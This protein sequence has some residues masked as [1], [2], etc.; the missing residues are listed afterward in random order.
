MKCVIDSYAWLEYFMGTPVGLKAKE[1]LESSSIE[2][3]VPSICMCEVYT[4][5]L[6]TESLEKAELFRGFMRALSAVIPL[7]ETLAVETAKV[8]VEMKKSTLGWGLADSVVLAT[9][10]RRKAQILTGDEHFRNL[11]DVIF[12]K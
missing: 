9:A 8:D 4:K 5:V 3:F 7:D 2:K 10:R 6:R 11:P 12:L 1:I